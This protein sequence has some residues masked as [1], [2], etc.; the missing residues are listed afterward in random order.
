VYLCF[1]VKHNSLNIL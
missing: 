1:E